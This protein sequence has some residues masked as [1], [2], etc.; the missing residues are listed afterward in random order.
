MY[1]ACDNRKKCDLCVLLHKMCCKMVWK[2]SEICKI[3]WEL[4][5]RW[6]RCCEIEIWQVCKYLLY[7]FHC[8]SFGD[9]SILF[10]SLQ[11]LGNSSREYDKAVVQFSVNN[12]LR[13]KTNL[14][15]HSPLYICIGTNFWWWPRQQSRDWNWDQVFESFNCLMEHI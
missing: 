7:L 13:H 15:K 5:S 11:I 9:Y 6:A 8:C 10:L 3:F 4:A 14:G 1:E 2:F 12:Q